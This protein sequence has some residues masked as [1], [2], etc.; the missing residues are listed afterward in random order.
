MRGKVGS[1]KKLVRRA[2]FIASVGVLTYGI[3]SATYPSKPDF[4][5]DVDPIAHPAT[6]AK[7]PPVASR[8][9]NLPAS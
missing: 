2:G 8:L 4:A 9:T 3:A 5:T 6:T 1:Q 7:S